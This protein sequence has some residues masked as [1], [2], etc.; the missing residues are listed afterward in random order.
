MMAME[1]VKHLTGAG[2]TLRGRLMVYDALYVETRV[3]SIEKRADCPVCGVTHRAA[4]E[5]IGVMGP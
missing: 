2:E 3:F 5:A 1:A 4:E